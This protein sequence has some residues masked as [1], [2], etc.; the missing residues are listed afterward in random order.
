MCK[1][2]T[3]GGKEGDALRGDRQGRSC[4]E[5]RKWADVTGTSALQACDTRQQRGLLSGDILN[6]SRTVCTKQGVDS[7]AEPQMKQQRTDLIDGEVLEQGPSQQPWLLAPQRPAGTRAS[8]RG[9]GL[10]F[11]PPLWGSR[12]NLTPRNKGT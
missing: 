7:R 8:P 4:W 1:G 11:Q 6:P 9:E 3:R 10:N 2:T 5:G 12:I